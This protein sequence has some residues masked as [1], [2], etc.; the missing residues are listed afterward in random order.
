MN[1]TTTIKIDYYEELKAKADKYDNG[2]I[3]I[4]IVENIIIG[5]GNAKNAPPLPV[6]AYSQL[7]DYMRKAKMYDEKETPKKIR[8][9]EYGWN[10]C[11][12]GCDTLIENKSHRCVDCGQ[13]LD[14]SNV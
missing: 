4:D 12:N 3:I 6:I 9:D 1:G 5:H 10:M 14:W 8:V 2:K 7:L 13:K 11:P